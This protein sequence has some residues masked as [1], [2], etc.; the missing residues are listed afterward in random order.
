MNS[1]LPLPQDRKLTVL[2]RL[3]PGCLGPQGMD[4]IEVF[5]AFAQQQVAHVDADF[6]HWQLLPRYDKSLAEMQY[7]IGNKNLSHEQASRY[8]Q[9]FNK[10]LDDFEQRLHDRLA[11]SIN[12]YLG[13]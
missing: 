10:N 2:C 7:K 8:L 6:V 11:D 3:E 13:H 9:M 12:A 4:N 1:R 5:C